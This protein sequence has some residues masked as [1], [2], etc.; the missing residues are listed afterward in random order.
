MTEYNNWRPD[1][2]YRAHNFQV[3]FCED[4]NCGLHIIGYD[5]E[6]NPMCEIVMSPDQT[7]AL[8]HT[9]KDFLYDK[10]TERG[11]GNGGGK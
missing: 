6:R 3:A 1:P 7:L 4:P 11:A 8:T 10:A 9:C 5:Q 2:R